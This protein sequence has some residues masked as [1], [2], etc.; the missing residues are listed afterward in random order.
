M[1]LNV[2]CDLEAPSWPAFGEAANEPA[3]EA[4]RRHALQEYL[5]AN[6]ERLRQRLLRHLGCPDLA[7]DCLHDA[8][9]RLSDVEVRAA[10]HSP[11]AY[12]YRMACNVAMD[13]LRGNRAW[14]YTGDADTE[15]E[16]FADE[17]PGPDHIAAARSELA[18]V[19]RAMARLPRRHR[20]VLVALRID[21]MTRQEVASRYGLSLR[22]VDTALRQALDYCAEHSG[23]EVHTGVNTPRRAL[24]ALRGA[25]SAGP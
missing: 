21:E 6:Y 22:T 14:Q 15:L 19:E 1:E 10:I 2:L 24:R 17:T 8:W 7:S 3:D 23:Q 25:T 18:A 5:V 9:L 20:S 13:R 12:I 4:H 16:H 11:E